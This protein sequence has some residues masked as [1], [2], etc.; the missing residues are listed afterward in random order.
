MPN[1]GGIVLSN[2]LGDYKIKKK[3]IVYIYTLLF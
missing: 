3:N 1:M 2:A